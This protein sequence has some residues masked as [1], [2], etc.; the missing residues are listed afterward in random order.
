MYA[1][2]IF[3]VL[4]L[5][6]IGWILAASHPVSSE[7]SVTIR[8]GLRRD[9]SG[10]TYMAL[11]TDKP[12]R[13]VASSKTIAEGK[14]GDRWTFRR[15]SGG[16]EVDREDEDLGIFPGPVRLEPEAGGLVEVLSPKRRYCRYRG[17]FEIGAKAHLV[18]VDEIL[19]EEYLYG[20]LPT[21]MP[22]G[23]HPEA[24][25]SQAVVARTYAFQHLYRHAADGYHLCDGIHCQGYLGYD[26][27]KERT[28]SA[29]D[30]TRGEVALYEGRP[31]Y[32]VYSSD[33]GGH[34]QNNEDGAV[35]KTPWPY[36]RA[37]PDRDGD[38]P[39]FCNGDRQHIWSR[40][41]PASELQRLLDRSALTKVGELQELR[42]LDFDASGRVK[43]VELIGSVEV[44]WISG[45]QFR[46]ILGT[47]RLPSTLMALTCLSDG[48]YRVDGRGFGH[49]V[50]FCQYGA[51][52]M[53]TSPKGY[54]YKDILAHYYRGVQVGLYPGPPE[55]RQNASRSDSSSSLT[56]PRPG[57]QKF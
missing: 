4:F 46:Q 57:M 38:G 27:E 5:V 35:G 50:G 17:I 20:V 56:S 16:I 21:E 24:L 2:R 42:F 25:K 1:P 36:L 14:A 23:F 49:G 45:N 51:N 54:T 31:I 44:K 9:F 53:A 41:F 8:I 22:A 10:L 3:Q 40:T 13:L 37:V 19:L 39:D 55:L 33:C 48:S 43:T 29:V 6:W 26:I 34:T 52:G 32:A 11:T 47:E 7:T 18:V 12:S 15:V 28:N 30:A